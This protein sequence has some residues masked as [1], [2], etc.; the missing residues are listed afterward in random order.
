MVKHFINTQT[1]NDSFRTLRINIHECI[2]TTT[3]S[4][5]QN[6]ISLVRGGGN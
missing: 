5:P 4:R 3:N 6:Y 2:L 1:E